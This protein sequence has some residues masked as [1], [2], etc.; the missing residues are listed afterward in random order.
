MGIKMAKI[1]KVFTWFSLCVVGLP[2]YAKLNVVT[3]TTTLAH[4]AKAL[5]AA[6]VEVVS[7]T[8]AGQDPHFVEAKP[9]YM[10]KLRRADLLISVGLGLEVGWIGLIRRGGRNPKILPGQKGHF[11]AGS[12]IE[13]LEVPKGKT[14]RSQGDVHP[15]GNPHFHLDPIRFLAVAKALSERLTELDPANASDYRANFKSMKESIEKSLVE[16]QER[17]QKSGIRKVIAY[18]K[19]LNYFFHRFGLVPVGYIEPKPGVAPSAK[20]IV[21][22]IRKIKIEK[23]RCIL[24]ED[25]YEETA[26]RRVAMK[27]GVAVVSVPVEVQSS[28]SDLIERLVVAVELCGK[29]SL[30][31]TVK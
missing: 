30:T 26:A 12:F 7:I 5:G 4:L 1:L 22:L 8:K 2:S 28:Y 3:T 19:S 10:V 27:D 13:A 14:D 15:E 11:E 6:H 17:I 29:A 25:Y 20:H 24:N 9:S 23:I 16:W 31:G 21:Q 18:H